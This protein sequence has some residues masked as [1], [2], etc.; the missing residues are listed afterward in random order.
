MISNKSYDFDGYMKWDGFAYYAYWVSADNRP[1]F[2]FRENKYYLDDAETEIKLTM[3]G[4]FRYEFCIYKQFSLILKIIYFRFLS[5]LDLDHSDKT[6][7]DFYSFVY[8]AWQQN[9]SL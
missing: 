2:Q 8:D 6:D 1:I 5:F 3:V 4:K 9:R 7:F